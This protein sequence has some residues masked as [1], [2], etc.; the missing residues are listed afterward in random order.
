M[1]EGQ[2]QL[3]FAA[4]LIQAG[5]LSTAKDIL[6]E[7]IRRSPAAV[8]AWA[9]SARLA[10]VMRDLDGSR[11]A[12]AA[13]I[14]LAPR[15]ADLLFEYGNM[16]AVNEEWQAAADLLDRARALA[17][18]VTH[19]TYV[20][21]NVR[22]RLGD[23]AGAIDCFRHVIEADE[24]LL[25]AWKSLANTAL[26]AGESDTAILAFRHV[27]DVDPRSEDALLGLSVALRTSGRDGEADDIKERIIAEDP[28]SPAARQLADLAMGR[29]SG[30][31]ALQALWEAHEAAP[32]APEPLCALGTHLSRI[33]RLPV[34]LPQL[35]NA[36]LE[37]GDHPALMALTGQALLDSGD[38]SEQ[39][40]SVLLH[41]ATL[42]A[43]ERPC[44]ALGHLYERRGDI[45]G[46][47]TWF[48]KA[49]EADPGNPAIHSNLLFALRHDA[50]ITPE[51]LFAEHRRYGEIQEAARPPLPPRA[52]TA[53][54]ADR[55]IRLGF[56]SPDFC[57]HAVTQFFEPYLDSIDRDRFE[58]TLYHTIRTIDQ[59]TLRLQ[60]KA[61]RWRHICAVSAEDAAKLIRGD[62]IDI[63]IDLAGHTA[64][65]GLP[66]FPY[67]PAPV[68]MTWIGY[69]ATTGLTCMDYRIVELGGEET[70]FV[71]SPLDTETLLS[72]G[73]LSAFRAP[74]GCPDVAPPPLLERGYVTFGSLNRPSKM[75]DEVL[76]T[77]V[78]V[79]TRVAGS[80]LVLMAATTEVERTR[81]MIEARFGAAGIDT[82]R[83]E[84][85][86]RLPLLPFM[87]MMA[88][89][90]VALDPFPFA[91][92][93]TSWLT[94]WM[95]VPIIAMRG[96]DS[97]SNAAFG[98]LA[99]AEV[100]ELAAETVE[101]YVDTAVSLAGDPDLLVKLRSELR[102]RLMLSQVFDRAKPG[103]ALTKGLLEAWRRHIAAHLA[104]DA[105]PHRSSVD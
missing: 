105:S 54:D 50:S 64:G 80:R 84:V 73:G 86:E 35:I 92:G 83:L 103:A 71:A 4:K 85:R 32:L 78:R 7:I 101:E 47:V 22:F 55:R 93:T 1:T 90:D 17:P 60:R 28:N 99:S 58:I 3:Q 39:T 16:L 34:I 74:A 81:A 44:N 102:P 23:H 96:H 43:A 53:A 45:A 24:S 59:V 8:D 77:W 67:R 57:S 62:G 70:R 2:G 9:L 40:E 68:Q 10:A 75:T 29:A 97:I 41:A 31:F 26:A 98:A 19:Y 48:R 51:A 56:V 89:I 37:N 88:D 30:A 72:I 46:A 79:L 12:Y 69:P 36:A 15:R 38:Y 18:Q 25:D 87:A 13:A 52:L 5:Q 95:G 94:L 65:N 76:D 27:L 11:A 21:G 49:H 6:A 100:P 20:L 61:D 42:D 63:L 66:V 104:T 14:D 33:G 91:G 82:A